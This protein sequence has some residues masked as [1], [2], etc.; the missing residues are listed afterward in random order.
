MLT[1][2]RA[3]S[4][5]YWTED[6]KRMPL[7]TVLSALKRTLLYSM[8]T[9]CFG[10]LLIAIVQLLRTMLCYVCKE[11]QKL[12][13][14]SVVRIISRIVQCCLWCFEAILKYVTYQAYIMVGMYGCNFCEGAKKAI[15]QVIANMARIGSVHF[16]SRLISYLSV[17][18]ITTGCVLIEYAWLTH[19]TQFLPGGDKF[20]RSRVLSMVLVGVIS[21]YCANSF[22]Q[23]YSITVD[24][25]ML[26]VC[27][28]IELN[29]DSPDDFYMGK[30]L[31]RLFRKKGSKADK[32]DY[33]QGSKVVPT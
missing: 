28:D 25:M 14:N 26:S 3:V 16:V 10:S 12:E 6:K 32:A 30:S 4:Q 7:V 18:V 13:D 1:V 11:T 20:V 27:V 23:V 24:T 22:M 29:R 21:F 15:T 17:I 33:S 31:K 5:W 19:D 2:S 9:V 8:G